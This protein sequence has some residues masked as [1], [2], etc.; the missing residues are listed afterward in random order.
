[1]KIKFIFSA[2]IVS[3]VACYSCNKGVSEIDIPEVDVQENI[4]LKNV[5]LSSCISTIRSTNALDNEYIVFSAVNDSTLKVEQKLLMS[6]YCENIGTEIKSTKENI[7]TINIIGG[8]C[9]CN[10]I[11]PRIANYE[12]CNLQIN[13]T[14]NFIFLRNTREYYTCELLFTPQLYHEIEIQY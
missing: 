11:C 9:G 5:V 1:M 8:D 14:Y 12:I 6:C 4:N 10:C 3:F 2:I 13:N 7:I